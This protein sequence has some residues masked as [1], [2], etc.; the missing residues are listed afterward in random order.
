MAEPS[1][2]RD[3]VAEAA[4]RVAMA[5]TEAADR[6]RRRIEAMPRCTRHPD[7]DR[8]PT[9]AC[10][11]CEIE[12]EA[13]A[14]EANRRYREERRA[15]VAASAEAALQGFPA[16]YRDAEAT[17]PAVIDWA[18]QFTERPADVPS[19][20]LLGSTGVGKTWQ[21]Y[22]A[23]R[24]ASTVPVITAAGLLRRRLWQ[25]STYADFVASMRPRPK[26][27][28]EQVLTDARTVDLLF[29]DDLGTAKGSEWVEEIT[30]RLVNGRYEDMRPSIFTSN[31]SLSELKEAIGDRVASRLAETCER[32]VLKGHDR[33][34]AP[35]SA[36]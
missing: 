10:P 1:E 24:I 2:L 15:E 12:R 6:L 21:A 17:E 34:R 29:I 5:R 16:R 36:A 3:L 7:V 22:G 13:E 33:R 26:F 18:Q 30:Y 11:E 25:A 8:E 9:G 20:L 14:V 35:R 32:I 23:I 4:E 31:L 19:L 27:D 28:P